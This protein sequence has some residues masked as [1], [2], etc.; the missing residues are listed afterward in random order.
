MRKFILG[1]ILGS[2]LATGIVY[3]Q[4]DV[5]WSKTVTGTK[6]K[7]REATI[8]FDAKT[9]GIHCDVLDAKGERVNGADVLSR[10]WPTI[11][12]FQ[13]NFATWAYAKCG[14]ELGVVATNVPDIMAVK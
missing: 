10:D 3:A 8:N 7:L 5:T 6:M 12:G 9:A 13:K 1:F 4:A 2:L 11:A 14:Q